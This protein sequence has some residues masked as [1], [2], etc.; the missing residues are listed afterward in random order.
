MFQEKCHI[1]E[2][3]SENLNIVNNKDESGVQIMKKLQYLTPELI[4][5]DSLSICL[6]CTDQLNEAY[7]FKKLCFMSCM[8]QLN[9]ANSRSSSVAKSTWIS[10]KTSKTI[11]RKKFRCEK[12]EEQFS[13]LK[14]ILVHCTNV[15]SM[16]RK[17]I[18]PYSCDLCDNRFISSASLIQHKKYH[19]S[20][21]YFI[22]SFCGKSFKTNCDLYAHEKIHFN[23]RTYSCSKC[24][25]AFNTSQ[26]LKTHIYVVHTDSDTWKYSCSICQKKFAMKGN[27]TEHMKRHQGTKEFACYL[28]KKTFVS[29]HEL[30]KHARAHSNVTVRVACNMC[31]KV[32]QTK[33][34]L[35]I[36]LSKVHGAGVMKTSHQTKK[37]KKSKKF[38]CDTCP[39]QFCEHLKF[40]KQC[41]I[42]DVN[43]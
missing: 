38:T 21:R 40:Q 19:Q 3:K 1:C 24:S 7:S 17:R 4:W 22:C 6:Q 36:H 26:N 41:P 31:E 39:S 8:K 11:S 35:N 32:Y 42:G 37:F 12:C 20:Q 33:R 27:F 15:H 10:R 2:K 13:L 18:K 9:G 43:K 14:E 34:S 16:D 23:K 29:Q 30:R 25:K 5:M 28:Y